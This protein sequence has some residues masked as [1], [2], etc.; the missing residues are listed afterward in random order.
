MFQ[1]TLHLDTAKHGAQRYEVS[2]TEAANQFAGNGMK[3]KQQ[4][5]QNAVGV[6]V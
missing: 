5:I 4:P 6:I 2:F 3:C 1:H